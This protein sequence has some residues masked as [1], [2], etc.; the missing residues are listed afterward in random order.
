MFPLLVHVAWLEGQRFVRRIH[1]RR[2]PAPAVDDALWRPPDSELC[3]AA[4]ATCALH[5]T[6]ALVGH[7]TRTYAFGM[8]LSDVLGRRPDRELLW[9]AAQ[10]HDLALTPAFDGDAPFELR[11]AEAAYAWC[12]EHDVAPH[13]AELVHEAIRLHTSLEAAQR[14]PEIALVH[15]GAGVDVIGY[16]LEDLDRGTVAEILDAWPRTGFA[17]ELHGLIEREAKKTPTSPI[18]VQWRLGFGD[19]IHAAERQLSRRA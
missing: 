18:G 16:R 13:H 14:E 7:C 4:A 9:V 6:P 19:R 11:G 8:A 15:F 5:S 3:R 1:R 10:L 12:L 2:H 17:D